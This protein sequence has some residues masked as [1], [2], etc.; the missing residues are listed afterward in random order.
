M[1]FASIL[2][3]RVGLFDPFSVKGMGVSI[4]MM[5]S[6]VAILGGFAIWT[7]RGWIENKVA[8]VWRNEVWEA[9]REQGQK[10]AESD[11]PESAQWLN[12]IL[13]SVWPLV[14]PDLF[15]SLADTL[16]DVMQA[17]L[18]KMVRMISVEDLG[19]GSES[20]RILGVRWLPMGLAASSVSVDGQ[21]RS[22]SEDDNS[23]NDRKVQGEGEVQDQSEQCK[24]K[25]KA[26]NQDGDSGDGGQEDQ[27]FAEGMEAEEGGFVNFEIA[28]AY[29]ARAAGKS[30]K[31][32][33][34][35]AHLYLVF[36]L[37]GG[38]RFPVWVELRGI[39]GTLRMRLQLTPDPPFC[40]LCT[41]TFLGQPNVDLSCVP[42]TRKGLNV[43]DL[44]FVS[45][46][47]QS[48]VNAAMAEYVAPKSLTLDLKD[49][50]VG[51]DF[52]KDT[53]SRGVLVVMIKRAWGFKEGDEK[54]AG[55]VGS[56]S[57][58]YVAVGWAKFGKPVWSTRVIVGEMDPVWEETT[59]IPVGHDEINADERLRVQL[60]DSD[61]TTAD[62]DLG[63][64]EVSLADLMKDPETKGKV[65]DRKDGLSGMKPGE[66]LPGTLEWSI[67]YFAKTGILPE[68]LQR[69]TEDKSIGSIEE[70]KRKVSETADRKLRE[71]TVKDESEELSQQKAQDLHTT[72]T[73]MIAS[74]PPSSDYPSGLL[75]IMVHQI[76]DLELAKKN[77][78]PDVAD[79]GD[80]KE[81][82]EGDD[83]PSSYCHIILNHT[84]IFRTRTKPKNSQ[85]FFN[86][87]TE[88]FIRDW[89]NTEVAL[90][91][92]DARVHEDDPILGI[93]VLP[94]DHVFK[95]RSQVNA[96]YP[97]FGGIG[98]GRIRI[99]MVFR[100]VQLQLPK[101][102]L[103]WDY[104]TLEVTSDIR[105]RD[106]SQALSSL[107]L[108]LRTNVSKGK[109]SSTDDG[110]KGKKDAHVHLAV[111]KRYCSNLII[112]FRRNR[113]GPDT[114]PAFAVIWL[115]NI[116]DEEPRTVTVPVWKNRD[117]SLKRAES[118]CDR[119]FGEKLGYVEVPLRFW[120]GLSGYHK[121]LASKDEN[122]HDMV[123]V[124]DCANADKEAR[125][126]AIANEHD[127][128]DSSNSDSDSQQSG[129]T[130]PPSSKA[131]TSG[132]GNDGGYTLT[133]L[134]KGP[135]GQIKDY[136]AH[137]GELHRRHRG[138]MQWKT[139]RTMK[140]MKTKAEHS[141]SR[142]SAR[143]AHKERDTGIEMES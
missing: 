55:L 3:T 40:A 87:G 13:A 109:M 96:S 12:S 26:T 54:L 17:S 138:L 9:E 59:F 4:A 84:K 15:T 29:R 107:R 1:G 106:L 61:R 38:I 32:R 79:D 89:R 118:S 103:G 135:V 69:Q 66:S 104:G 125:E 39:V 6:T 72:T 7:L 105:S 44:P 99:S 70:L 85:P 51:D 49:M 18:P 25:D 36:Y 141:G 30:L 114:T 94:L 120:P 90:A 8:E 143:F 27:N 64:V 21:L 102:L 126:E 37:F 116:P 53:D 19:Q 71:A 60:W 28:F 43:M 41:L 78:N 45:G 112:E 131:K 77:K 76:S 142:L 83:L 86:A 68:Q 57:D 63:T 56:S 110:W 108:K 129:Q 22:G 74:A 132:D 65:L 115:Q 2:G 136:T 124:L 16:E 75:S 134:N 119:D 24:E 139:P 133:A 58:T 82:Q 121:A 117:H 111:R 10:D 123:E 128:T 113:L 50:I 62:D 100:S 11:T 33:A 91:I 101:E 93:V 92:R 47:V 48:S 46:F 81:E 34:K 42:L 14:N 73:H 52:K 67:G 98:Y 23:K 140:W 95:H 31:T 5:A 137:K 97:L 35:N 88:R 122:I 20:L 80:D 130:E 127:A